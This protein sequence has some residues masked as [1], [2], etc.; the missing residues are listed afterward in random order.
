LKHIS[1]VNFD[2]FQKIYI[3][4]IGIKSWIRHTKTSSWLG[5][6]KISLNNYIYV[7]WWLFSSMLYSLFR[8]YQ[9]MEIWMAAL[10]NLTLV[11]CWIYQPI[12]FDCMAQRYTHNQW[13]SWTQPLFILCC[14]LRM[15]MSTSRLWKFF[16][17]FILDV[18]DKIFLICYINLD[19]IVKYIDY[20]NYRLIL[21]RYIEQCLK[22]VYLAHIQ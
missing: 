6:T 8:V 20:A 19:S 3:L 2:N 17:N 21:V 16:E 7:V 14:F 4:I 18:N 13:L 1:S 15:G 11:G 12:M 5:V 9:N 10:C 22:F